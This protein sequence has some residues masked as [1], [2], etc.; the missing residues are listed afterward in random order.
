MIILYGFAKFIL[1][2]VFENCSLSLLAAVALQ[3]SGKYFPIYLSILYT[4]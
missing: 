2:Y 3:F 4:F 1:L